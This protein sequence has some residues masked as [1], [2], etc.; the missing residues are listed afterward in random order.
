[1]LSEA[2]IRP[3]A[4][5]AAWRRTVA[6]PVV[7]TNGVFDLFHVGHVHLLE[8]AASLGATLI[9]GINTDAS[10]RRLGKGTDR[11]MIPGSDRARIVAA[12]G[13]V[14]G[15]V[16]FEEDTPAALIALLHPEILV[17]GGDYRPE[18]V[19]GADLVTARGGRVVIVPLLPDQS[20]TRILERL[21]APS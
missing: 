14:D 18:T 8:Q 13:C 1:M 4:E 16:L 7:F 21:R 6:G 20:A 2:K 11:P 3:R 12:L 10:V 15:V 19:V 5:M 9:V 17:K